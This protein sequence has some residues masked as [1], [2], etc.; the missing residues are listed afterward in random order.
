MKI[1][2]NVIYCRDSEEEM[3]ALRDLLLEKK[4]IEVNNQYETFYGVS[5]DR[6]MRKKLEDL[7]CEI[8]VLSYNQWEGY[9]WSYN[10]K[11]K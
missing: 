6:K 2:G 10:I 9:P 5:F 3:N 1:R 4:E 7:D 8:K 11:L